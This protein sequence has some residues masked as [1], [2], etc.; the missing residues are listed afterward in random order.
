[1][2]DRKERCV[3][4][5]TDVLRTEPYPLMRVWFRC[6]RRA[7]YWIPKW[8][9]LYQILDKA[10][11]IEGSNFQKSPWLEI[12]EEIEKISARRTSKPFI[13]R[14]FHKPKSR[15]LTEE[16]IRRLR[17]EKDKKLLE[18]IRKHREAERAPEELED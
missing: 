12:L 2:S 14:R 1:M 18:R 5:S 7:F 4:S 15:W 8:E 6:G 17:E 9:E 10:I 16:E 3:F 13:R 11:L